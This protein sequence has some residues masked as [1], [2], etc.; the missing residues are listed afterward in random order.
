MVAVLVEADVGIAADLANG[1]RFANA[2]QTTPP[3]VGRELL[4]GGLAYDLLVFGACCRRKWAI[5]SA[6]L[7]QP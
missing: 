5:N 6:S 3:V 4:G 7:A 2:Q 1:V